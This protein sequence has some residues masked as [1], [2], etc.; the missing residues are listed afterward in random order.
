MSDK[1]LR[2]MKMLP[3]EQLPPLIPSVEALYSA[4]HQ[5]IHTTK[6]LYDPRR[7]FCLNAPARIRSEDPTMEER[8]SGK[9]FYF[10]PGG[11]DPQ[12]LKWS[13]TESDDINNANERKLLIYYFHLAF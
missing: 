13:R 5:L 9:G 1:I 10:P 12:V 2:D 3:M 4:F 8:T 11:D 7:G 6:Q